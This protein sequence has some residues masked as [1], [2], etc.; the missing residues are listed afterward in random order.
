MSLL[1]H[2]Q[3]PTRPVRALGNGN[4]IFEHERRQNPAASGNMHAD[5]KY[6]DKIFFGY[7]EGRAGN[8][9]EQQNEPMMQLHV[10]EIILP[11]H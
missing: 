2:K 7:Q 1:Q 8:T 3:F 10:C 11:A 6:A 4:G 9:G 5:R